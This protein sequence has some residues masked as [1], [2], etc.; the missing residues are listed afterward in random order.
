MAK[1]NKSLSIV[2]INRI[3]GK[4]YKLQNNRFFAFDLEKA[5]SDREF[6]ISYITNKDVMTASIVVPKTTPPEEMDD[7]IVV[8]TYEE[9]GLDTAL[10]YKIVYSQSQNESPESL[11]FNVFVTNNDIVANDLSPIVANTEYIDYLAY[12]P[13][14]MRALYQR[15]ILTAN[16]VDECFIYLQRND[17]F[18]VVYRNGE[19]FQ[20]RSLRFNLKYLCDKFS[21]ISGNRVTEDDFNAMLK[22]DGINLENPAERDYIIQIFDDLFFYVGDV[23]TSIN[24]IYKT[25][26]KNIYFGTDIGNIKGVEIFIQDRLGLEYKS[27]EFNIALNTKEF[28]DITQLDMLMV[29]TA[30]AYLNELDDEFN[31]SMFLRPPPFSQRTSGRLLM[32]MLAGAAIG[33]AY[34]GFQFAYGYINEM[35]TNKKTEEYN[36]AHAEETRIKSAIEALEKQIAQTNEDTAKQG[37]LLQDKENKLTSIFNKKVN[38]PMKGFAIYDMTNFVNNQDGNLIA[39]SSKDNNITFTVNTK[40]DKKMTELLK[41]ISTSGKYSVATKIIHNS[42]KN[43][44]RSDKYESNITLEIL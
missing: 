33:F 41:E 1:E 15:G 28:D 34:P 17:A 16:N 36:I 26:I 23:I 31:F 8:K 6:Y 39:L 9:L 25:N 7:V 29:L 13:F 44:T 10:D 4:A 43:A 21:E 42:D 35:Q 22:K 19:Y 14:L 2:V 3:K 27:F 18:L 37:E 32:A 38:Y 20:S 5:K 12:S 11:F 40:T 30:Q 24:K